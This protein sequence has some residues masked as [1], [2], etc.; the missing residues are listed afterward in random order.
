MVWLGLLRLD[1]FLDL[2]DRKKRATV[3]NA[4]RMEGGFLIRVHFPRKEQNSCG[5]TLF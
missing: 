5:V 3:R 1:R 2:L 4:T